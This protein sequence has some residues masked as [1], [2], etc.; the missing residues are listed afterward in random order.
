[1]TRRL[2]VLVCALGVLALLPAQASAAPTT[3]MKC[4]VK[5]QLLPS[6]SIIDR[7]TITYT[8]LNNYFGSSAAVCPGTITG[9]ITGTTTGGT[10]S[11]GMLTVVRCEFGGTFN[12]APGVWKGT[13][14]IACGLPGTPPPRIDCYG[15][16]G[17]TVSSTG[18]IV[19]RVLGYCELPGL[20]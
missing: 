20:E 17:G 2:L 1:M 7:G 6:A 8:C 15:S 9:T 10:C 18:A 12:R 5:G 19:G 3:Q 4:S 11:I 16:G 13:L 14:K